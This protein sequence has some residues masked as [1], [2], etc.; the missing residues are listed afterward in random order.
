MGE[1]CNLFLCGH[2][3]YLLI[4]FHLS[5]SKKIRVSPKWCLPFPRLQMLSNPEHFQRYLPNPNTCPKFQAVCPTYLVHGCLHSVKSK[6]ASPAVF[7]HLSLW[8]KLET[9][10]SLFTPS[11][12]SLTRSNSSPSPM[13]FISK[14]YRVYLN[15]PPAPT[16]SQSQ[17]PLLTELLYN[18][19]LMSLSAYTLVAPVQSIWSNYSNLLKISIRSSHSPSLKYVLDSCCEINQTCVVSLFLPRVPHSL[20]AHH[21]P[22]FFSHSRAPL[23]SLPGLRAFEHA[24]PS[25]WKTLPAL[26]VMALFILCS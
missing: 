4:V 10:E 26:C 21:I 22:A 3:F 11:S 1:T 23:Q 6:P 19:L 16:W 15:I 20:L 18:V 25:T 5:N 8:L 9:W 12:P 17:R 13:A 7:Q 2:C 24:V 14:L